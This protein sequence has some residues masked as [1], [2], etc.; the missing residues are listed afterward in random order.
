VIFHPLGAG[1][2]GLGVA[3][4]VA[5]G[6]GGNGGLLAFEANEHSL[7]QSTDRRDLTP[8]RNEAQG[9]VEAEQRSG[10]VGRVLIVALPRCVLR[11]K[12][13]ASRW[14]ASKTL[15]RHWWTK[16]SG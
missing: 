6:G 16:T 11:C 10:S 4:G 14:W 2:A 7:E 3:A 1:G 15:V 9:G 12:T 13:S 8:V 5:S